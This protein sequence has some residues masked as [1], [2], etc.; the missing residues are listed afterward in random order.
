M[1][2]KSTLKNFKTMLAEAKLPEKTIQ[3]CL[4]GDLAGEFEQLKQ[5]LSD[6]QN[7]RADALDAGAD[8]AELAGQLEALRQE[9]LTH[10]YP[11]KV[12]ALPQREFRALRTEHPPRMVDAAGDVKVHDDD[13]GFGVNMVTFFDTLVRRCVVDPVLDDAEWD[14]LL[15]EKLTSSQYD[16]LALA[17]WFVNV[18][19]VDIPFSYAASKIIRSSATG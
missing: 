3:V 4:R 13:S 18:R 11:F 12:R 7:D 10:T 19:D 8:V 5:L 1:S 15:G 16:A 17:A 14:D 6:A 9:M 2:G